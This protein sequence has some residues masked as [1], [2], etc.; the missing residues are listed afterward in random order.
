[1][2]TLL[3]CLLVVLFFVAVAA[4]HFQK[5]ARQHTEKLSEA[6]AMLR[7]IHLMAVEYS[8]S[9]SLRSATERIWKEIEHYLYPDLVSPPNPNPGLTPFDAIGE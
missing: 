4:V 9:P 8:G 6:E 3:I 2:W 7:R 1:M 5:K